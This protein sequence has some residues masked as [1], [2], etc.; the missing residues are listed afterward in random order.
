MFITWENAITY[1]AQTSPVQPSNERAKVKDANGSI[2]RFVLTNR[3]YYYD[4]QGIL[5][6][7][8]VI[9]RFDLVKIRFDDQPPSN[10]L[11]HAREIFTSTRVSTK[12]GDYI[13]KFMVGFNEGGNIEEDVVLTQFVDLQQFFSEPM[14]AKRDQMMQDIKNGVFNPADL[15]KVWVQAAG[16]QSTP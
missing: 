15:G 13:P 6:V 9:S 4:Q 12:A 2:D 8:P 5:H 14:Q 16:F 1:T 7:Q 10:L 3:L 11:V